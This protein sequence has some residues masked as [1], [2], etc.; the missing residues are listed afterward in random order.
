MSFRDF[1]IISR[2]NILISTIPTAL[3]GVILSRG[4]LFSSLSLLYILLYFLII[5]F[6]CNIN[7]L[8]D[9][10]VDSRYKSYMSNA[11]KRVGETKIKMLLFIETC[12]IFSLITYFYLNGKILTSVFAFSGFVFSYIYSASPLRL[13]AKGFFSFIPTFFG[14]YFISVLGGYALYSQIDFHIVIFAFSYALLNQGITF[15]NTCEDFEEDNETGIK[16]FAHFLG[17]RKTLFLAVV[18][19]F[20]G[21]LN[22]F[23]YSKSTLFF[24][25]LIF[26]FSQILNSFIEN[27][28][29]K[30][31][32]K[33]PLWF[34]LVRYPL[35][36]SLII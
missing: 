2:A 31:A 28:A 33:M 9:V 11:V 34:F 35:L 20:L 16:T 24:V 12:L 1:L 26:V 18:L 19:T 22:L 5:T 36:I 6:A 10:E 3:F 15:V 25:P 14:L 4:P 8:S 7:C 27:N 29:K 21:G 30:Y 13:K 17:F 32:S 23:F